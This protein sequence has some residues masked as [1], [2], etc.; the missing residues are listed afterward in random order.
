M[1]HRAHIMF[2][3]ASFIDFRDLLRLLLL[4]LD[5]LRAPP[6]EPVLLLD[7]ILGWLRDYS[8]CPSR[9]HSLRRRISKLI[10]SFYWVTELSLLPMYC[11]EEAA[12]S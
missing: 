12:C 4:L 5:F 8:A 2:P 3:S 1:A 10:R 9:P 11:T 6:H 7:S